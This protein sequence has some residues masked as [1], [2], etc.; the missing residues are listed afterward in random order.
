MERA[1]KVRGL[2]EAAALVAD[3][4]T[5]ALGGYL[6]TNKPAAFVREI[7]RRRVRDLT[8]VSR[9]PVT[10]NPVK[11]SGTPGPPPSS[12]PTLG[13]HTDEVLR[14]VLGYP[15]DKVRALREARAIA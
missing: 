13:Q 3:G 8:I 14:K 7:I 11:L 9:V 2:R 4:M 10:G 5:V 6:A 15:P 1:S 12:P